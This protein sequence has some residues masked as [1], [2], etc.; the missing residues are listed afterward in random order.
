MN[1]PAI[2]IKVKKATI[3]SMITQLSTK[4]LSPIIN[5]ILARLLV[6]ETFGIVATV[7][8]VISF[9]DIIF[10]EGFS[11]YIV[12]HDFRNKSEEWDNV[13]V[14]F[15][16]NLAVALLLWLLIFLFQH[17][18]AKIAG[19][20]SLNHVI[21]IAA[22]QLPINALYSLLSAYNI[23]CFHNKDI[24]ISKLAQALVPFIITIPMAI[25]GYRYWSIIIG[26]I[27]G[28]VFSTLILVVNTEW[29]PTFFYNLQILKTMLPFC[30]WSILE[31]LFLW[32]TTWVD[33]II[34]GNVFSDYYLGLYVTSYNIVNAVMSIITSAIVPVFFV[35]LSRM[36]KEDTLFY[37]IFL[38]YQKM[39]AYFLFPIGVGI[40]FYRDFVTNILLGK[41]WSEASFI[42][43]VYAFTTSIRI[44][45][46]H[47]NSEA[48]K[49]IGQ[50]KLALFLQVL[51]LCIL[52]PVCMISVKYGFWSLVYARA[53]IR[54]DLIIPGLILASFLMKHKIRRF[55]QNIV[56]PLL[57]TMIMSFFVIVLKQINTSMFWQVISG[58][59]CVAVY[60]LS[61]LIMDI[62]I[63]VKVYSFYLYKKY[64]L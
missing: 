64:K 31:G 9:T 47:I 24:F 38:K 25:V 29:R 37:L 8:I 60:I 40:F 30:I 15:W 21:V 33:I 4:L 12:Q 62:S 42:I 50:P 22:M 26:S 61:M 52:I 6:P 19:N 45:L 44:T 23:R 14:A 57:C 16:T 36:Q 58:F 1:D 13:N 53:L 5:I 56:Q 27:I 28:M 43:G 35:A 32:L 55:L 10:N 41:S 59:V 3:W 49:A 54:F 34:I 20:S 51:D 7:T 18:I 46:V 2:M 63:L 17:P 48:F 11:K 39:I